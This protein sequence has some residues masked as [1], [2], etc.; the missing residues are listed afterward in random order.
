MTILPE[1]ESEEGQH[2]DGEVEQQHDDGGGEAPTSPAPEP[3]PMFIAL[4]AP[5][6][7]PMDVESATVR[8]QI[9]TDEESS[10]SRQFG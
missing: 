3:Q 1:G 4:Q 8:I 2:H 9:D 10:D 5:P 6:G 7:Q